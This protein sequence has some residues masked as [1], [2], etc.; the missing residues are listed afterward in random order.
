MKVQKR[1]ISLFNFLITLF[2]L[3]GITVLFVYNILEVNRLSIDN[4]NARIEINKSIAVNNML[5]TEIERLSTFDKIKH[6]VVE[7]KQMSFPSNKF[8]KIVINKSDFDN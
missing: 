2:T 7:K 5:Q 8:K 6:V 1:K 3:S 4:N